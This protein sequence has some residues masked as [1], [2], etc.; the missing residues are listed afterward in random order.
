MVQPFTIVSLKFPS[1]YLKDFDKAVAFYTKIFGLSHNPEPRIQGW[2]LGDT[3]LTLFP[4]E[5]L[6][7]DPDANPRNAEFAIQVA[8]PEQVDVLYHAFLDAGAKSLMPP[9]DTEMYDKMRFCAVDDPFGI[10]VDV[11]C[12]L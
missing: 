4:A 3:W 5:D 1:F 8:M 11:Y 9:E 7:H 2:K 6:G 12:P 10:R